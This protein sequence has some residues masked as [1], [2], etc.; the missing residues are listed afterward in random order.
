MK[1]FVR[2]LWRVAW[3]LS[4]MAARHRRWLIA[5]TA[6]SVLVVAARI[7]Y[8]WALRGVVDTAVNQHHSHSFAS[9]APGTGSPTL[10]LGAIFLGI[11]TTQGVGEFLQRV[12]FARFS[13]GMVRGMRA[14]ALAGISRG[15]GLEGKAAGD[16]ISRIIGDASRFKSGLKS[17]L[18]RATQ[19]GLFFV[20]VSVMLSLLDV[21]MGLVFFC[22]C[23][24]LL[25]VATFGASRVNTITRR[26]RKKEGKLAAR[27]HAALAGDAKKLAALDAGDRAARPVDAKSTRLE[28][29][30]IIAIHLTLGLTVCGVLAIGLHD[31]R[32]GLIRP[33]DLFV[34]IYYLVIVHNQ[35]LKLGR[36][37]L[38]L[39]RFLVSAERLVKLADR[40]TAPALAR[41][42]DGLFAD[43]ARSAA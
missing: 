32:T 6:G 8:A 41:E 43:W 34:A 7:A 25:A 21:K 31:A 28:G 13:I 23:V 4:P 33:T 11:V 39:G 24:T 30:T 3:R 29:L 15:A 19:S 22:G 37:T 35:M 17:L 38:K 16:V 18:L 2:R 5:G 40:P 9:L 27:M 1:R 36:Q 26:L 42:P 20:T 12:S 10:W 14:R